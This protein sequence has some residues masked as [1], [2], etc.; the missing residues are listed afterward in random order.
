MPGHLV[1]RARGSRTRTHASMIW[2]AHA[3]RVLQFSRT[4]MQSNMIQRANVKRI[5]Q[6][7]QSYAGQTTCDSKKRANWGLHKAHQIFHRAHQIRQ[8]R[9][10]RD[11][12]CCLQGGP[13]PL[14]QDHPMSSSYL[15]FAMCPRL[16]AHK[17][18]GFI[19]IAMCPRLWP[20][21][22]CG[23]LLHRRKQN[24]TRRA[25]KTNG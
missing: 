16:W 3:K 11:S 10:R 24:K 2:S 7:M 4:Q 22:N 6:L 13:A 18:C 9:R 12:C 19:A 17:N 20:H 15:G 14:L 8:R 5:W 25:K 23:R 1:L 21:K